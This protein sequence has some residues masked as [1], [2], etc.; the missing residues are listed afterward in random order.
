[1]T[2]LTTWSASDP[3]TTTGSTVDRPE[4][5]SV[6]RALGFR[7]ER[8]PL[9]PGLAPDAPAEDVL[10]AYRDLIE[11]LVSAEGFVEVDVAALH[12]TGQPAFAAT[13]AAARAKFLAE[14]THADDEVRFFAAGRGVFYLHTRDEARGEEVHAVLCEAGDLLFVP[15]GTTHWFD[16]GTEPSFTAVRFFRDPEGWVGDFTGS[17]LATQFP[18]FDA[19][20]AQADAVTAGA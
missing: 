4:I 12:P 19:L 5:E 9:A 13:A 18:D 3:T 17:D 7:L 2:A 20:A 8:W 11:G 14:H 1:M 6:L 10:A 16:M 15:A